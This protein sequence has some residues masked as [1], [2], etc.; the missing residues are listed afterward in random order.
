MAEDKRNIGRITRIIGPIVEVDFSGTKGREYVPDIYNALR[1]T[2]DD[3][4][5]LTLEVQAHLGSSKVRAIALDSVDGLHR[6]MEVEDTGEPIKFPVS[7]RVL[8]RLFN[9]VGDIIDD[10]EPI[11]FSSANRERIVREPPDFNQLD[12]KLKVLRTGIKVID[13]M[14]PFPWGG[15]IGLFG[16]AGVGKTVF[17]KELIN[18]FSEWYKARSVYS[19]VGE[20]TREGNDLWAELQEN[21]EVL[22]N[23]ALVFGQMNEPPGNRFRA[24]MAAVTLAEYFRELADCPHCGYKEYSYLLKVCPACKRQV[25]A[26]DQ[27]KIR[28]NNVLLFMDNLFRYV[29]AGAELSTLLGRMP[30]AVGYQPTLEM[31][32]GDMEERITSTKRGSITSVQAVYVPADDLTDPA[33]AAIFNHLDARV[34]LSRDIM[35]KGI[36]P[37][38]DPLESN[39]RVLDIAAITPDELQEAIKEQRTDEREAKWIEH[40]IDNG[41]NYQLLVANEVRRILTKNI[42]LE[43]T[44]RLLGKGELKEDDRITYESAQRILRFFSQPFIVSEQYTGKPGRRVHI[45]DTVFGFMCLAYDPRVTDVPEDN[46]RYI[47]TIEEV[48]GYGEALREPSSKIEKLEELKEK[49][50]EQT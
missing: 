49:I 17:V 2:H 46:F 36:Y 10:G 23:V 9:V 7:E 18:T 30:S 15:K 40:L 4:S 19:G 34:V 45:W 14:A 13:L 24:G 50:E 42:E 26:G 22:K 12:S 16:G 29:Q 21:K 3:G 43:S 20:R 37:A 35:E 27:E 31:E 32:L 44:V 8:G 47:G 28:R 38:V 48:R 39:S 11:Q 5:T 41:T 33:P 1:V 6:G 25:T